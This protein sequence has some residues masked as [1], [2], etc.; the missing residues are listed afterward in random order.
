MFVVMS[1]N[2]LNDGPRIGA[3]VAVSNSS[4]LW[5]DDPN[6]P[7]NV[8]AFA[9]DTTCFKSGDELLVVSLASNPQPQCIPGNAASAFTYCMSFV[10]LT[11]D[12]G[13]TG[14]GI[15]L[16]HNPTGAATDPL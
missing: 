15:Q 8:A 4:I 12:A 9:N 16:Q 3:S 10:V 7:G 1:K 2:L 6:N 14:N 13:V 11:K 5:A